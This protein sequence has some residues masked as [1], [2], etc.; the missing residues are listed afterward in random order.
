MRTCTICKHHKLSEIYEALVS[1]TVCRD[2]GGRYGTSKSALDHHKTQVSAA[3]VRAKDAADVV[4]ADSLFDKIAQLEQEARRLGKKAEDAGDLRAA[5]APVR[6]LFAS[7][8]CWP[9]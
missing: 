9:R 4:R 7:W 1:G 2:I 6:E 5:M 8:S 3:L